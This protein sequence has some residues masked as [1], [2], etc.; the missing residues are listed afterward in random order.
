MRRV[1]F[2]VAATL[3]LLL[4][5]WLLYSWF[6]SYVPSPL[7]FEP[8]DGSLMIMWWEGTAPSDAQYDLFNPKA[9]EKFM[10]VRG[11]MRNMRATTDKQRFGFRYLS[12]GGIYRG[13]VYHI[14]AIPFWIL[15]PAT[16]VLPALWIHL[17]RRQRDRVNFGHCLSCGYDL[18]ESKEKC[19]ECGTAVKPAVT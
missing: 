1:A 17:R 13:M 5:L 14:V 3:S 12:G 18:R 9:G 11:I 8:I 2:N 19:P 15:I 10:G 4:C 7:R 6:R 16:A